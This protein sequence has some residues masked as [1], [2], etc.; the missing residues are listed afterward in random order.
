M[1]I[2]ECMRQR[3]DLKYA[4]RDVMEE[5][6]YAGAYVRDHKDM[7]DEASRFYAWL[8]RAALRKIAEKDAAC[9]ELVRTQTEQIP[10]TNIHKLGTSICGYCPN[11]EQGLNAQIN[12]NYC[13]V[14]GQPLKWRFEF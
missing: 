7:T 10:V 5:L 6:K 4:A 9:L 1:L 2:T 3:D 14:C 13:G 11:C 12:P 8:F